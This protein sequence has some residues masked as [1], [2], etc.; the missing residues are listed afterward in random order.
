M[1]EAARG[2]EWFLGAALDD[3]VRIVLVH[4]RGKRFRPVALLEL[5]LFTLGFVCLLPLLILIGIVT[6]GADGEIE[7]PFPWLRLRFFDR[8]HTLGLR[9]FGPDNHLIEARDAR[10][11]DRAAGDG[12]VGSVLQAASERGLVAIEVFGQEPGEVLHAYYG[13]QPLMS[14][15]RVRN[16]AQALAVLTQL[17]FFIDDEGDAV[18]IGRRRARLPY[19][20]ILLRFL[21]VLALLPLLALSAGGRR[22]FGEAL[23]DVRRVPPLE[24]RV[25]LR[26]ETLELC[27]ARG[28]RAYR[29]EVVNGSEILAVAHAPSLDYDRDVSRVPPRLRVLLRHRAIDTSFGDLEEGGQALADAIVTVTVRLRRARPELGLAVDFTEGHCPYCA[30]LYALKAGTRCPTC[31][32]PAQWTT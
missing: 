25:T 13:G 20:V 22:W 11:S 6:A 18:T 32:A 26:A 24:Y 8:W 30:S 15:P 31:G 2:F 27:E 1:R 16:E 19:V 9:I 4:D 28:E 17:G 23:L 3:A 12:Y 7:L 14:E 29:R 21:F 10:P 5:L